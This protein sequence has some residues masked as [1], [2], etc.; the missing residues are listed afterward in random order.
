[1]TCFPENMSFFYEYLYTFFF[2]PKLSVDMSYVQNWVSDDEEKKHKMVVCVIY[3]RFGCRICDF[4][5]REAIYM[6]KQA[7]GTGHC[8]VSSYRDIFG[9]AK[10]YLDSYTTVD[11][12]TIDSVH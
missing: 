12:L 11:L 9:E 3:E 7:Y 4:S 5:V 10:G 1:M 8:S 2:L 6:L